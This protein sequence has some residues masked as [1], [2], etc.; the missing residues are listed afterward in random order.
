NTANHHILVPA[1][2]VLGAVVMVAADIISQ[3]PGSQSNL[4]INSVTAL[5]GIPVVI[6]LIIKNQRLSSI[7]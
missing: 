1:S 4:P 2:M 7:L 5:I 6:Y 3:L